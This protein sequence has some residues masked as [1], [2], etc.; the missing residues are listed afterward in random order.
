MFM[1][2]YQSCATIKSITTS[3]LSPFVFISGTPRPGTRILS[4]DL[5][6]FFDSI[7]NVLPSGSGKRSRAPFTACDGDSLHF[8]IKL[9]PTCFR[10]GC[11]F[12]CTINVIGGYSIFGLAAREAL[13]FIFVPSFQPAFI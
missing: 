3:P 6:P 10:N 13:N 12:S 2:R 5:V 9:L 4:P 8:H 7:S 11:F 1:C